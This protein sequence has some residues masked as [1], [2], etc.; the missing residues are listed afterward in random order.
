MKLNIV[1]VTVLSVIAI[2]GCSS[3]PR[4]V[5][6]TPVASLGTYEFGQTPE[7]RQL[8]Y[9]GREYKEH[10]KTMQRMGM[11]H[12]ERLASEEYQVKEAIANVR[13]RKQAE[14]NGVV[15][16]KPAPA[17]VPQTYNY[18]Q[19][20]WAVPTQP[21]NWGPPTSTYVPPVY[22]QPQPTYVAVYPQP[23][24]RPVVTY[25][26]N[27][28][29]RYYSSSPYYYGSWGYGSRGYRGGYR[30]VGTGVYSGGYRGTP[31]G[32]RGGSGGGSQNGRGS[33]SHGSGGRR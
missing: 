14:T 18:Q 24:I 20:Q 31:V 19:R 12:E 10:L 23:A 33:G 30:W 32:H 26:P 15:F 22:S 25:Y 3:T 21:A 5:K 8:K 7:Q 29:Y 1:I 13:L 16:P 2:T 4:V 9:R 17:P 28:S 6:K 27:Y 11:Q